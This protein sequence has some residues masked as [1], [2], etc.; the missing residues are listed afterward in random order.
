MSAILGDQWA[1]RAQ[2]FAKSKGSGV[3]R[4]G[5]NLAYLKRLRESLPALMHRTIHRC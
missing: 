5:I 1:I 4:A 2:D 3:V